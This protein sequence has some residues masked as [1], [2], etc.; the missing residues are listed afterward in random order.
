MD[1]QFRSVA[2]GGFHK[3]DVLNFVENTAKDHAQQLQE[4][5]QKLE[6]QGRQLESALNE[7][8]S[9]RAQTEQTGEE[10]EQLRARTEE[11]TGWLE[12]AESDRADLSA[13]LD[14]MTEKATGL[15]PDALAYRELK[16]RTAGVEL[17]AH[18]RAQAVEDRAADRAEQV[19][20]GAAA[21]L[22]ELGQEYDC[23]RTQTETTAAYARVQ[24]QQAENAL[25]QLGALL[26]G[27]AAALEPLKRL[28]D[29]R[30]GTAGA[31][32]E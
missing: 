7:R 20:A 6:E 9:L 15:E 1:H 3:Q 31:A 21:W 8:D 22:K 16:E 32:E 10:L 19:R 2:F 24:L 28:L 23:L 17:E 4:L 26:G 11:L 25:D 14:E 29:G 13:R 27:Q 5:Q 30:N 12:R 18:R